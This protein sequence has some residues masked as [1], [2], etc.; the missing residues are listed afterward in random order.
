MNIENWQLK[1]IR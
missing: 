1:T